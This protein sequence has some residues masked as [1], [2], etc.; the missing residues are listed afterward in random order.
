MRT[1]FALLLTA[2][3]LPALAGGNATIQTNTGQGGSSTMKISWA[4]ADTVRFEP[5]GQPGYMLLRDGKVYSVTNAGGQLMVMDMSSLNK[6][7]G[8]A[9]ASMPTG[10]A[11]IIANAQAVSDWRATGD[12]ET[13]AG[14]DGE[15][16]A[17]TWTDTEGQAHTDRAVLS[18]DPAVMEM[19]AAFAT[20]SRVMMDSAA[21]ESGSNPVDQRLQAENLGVLRFADKFQVSSISG[22]APPAG[23]LELP[24]EPQDLGGALKGMRDAFNK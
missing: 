1:L 19:S 18:D 12:E 11:P 13:I 9:G 17:I 8:A 6:L 22:D 3:A 16:Y 15:V 7:S 24:A 4:D 23:D 20:F 2:A 10:K 21:R 5:Q 14:I